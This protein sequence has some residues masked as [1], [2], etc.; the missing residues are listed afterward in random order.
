MPGVNEKAIGEALRRRF[1]ENTLTFMFAEQ[2]DE[3]PPLK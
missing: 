1:T 3:F 2:N